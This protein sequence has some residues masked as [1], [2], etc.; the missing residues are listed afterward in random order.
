MVKSLKAKRTED[1]S[2]M[3]PGSYTIKFVED[4]DDTHYIAEVVSGE[5]KGRRFK[6]LKPRL[7]IWECQNAPSTEEI[8]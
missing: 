7:N 3:P 8:Q 5:F 6:M 2:D 4:F 1:I